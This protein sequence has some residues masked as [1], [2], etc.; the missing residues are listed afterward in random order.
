[1]LDPLCREA[2]TV[3]APGG[4]LLIVHSEVC[5]PDA[6]L[7]A[8]A[9]A[10]LAADV[11][12]RHRGPLGPRMR[13]RRRALEARGRLA[14]G[15]TSEEVLVLRGRLPSRGRAAAAGPLS[16][17]SSSPP[18]LRRPPPTP[19]SARARRAARFTRRP[20]TFPVTGR[21]G[22]VRAGAA[23]ATKWIA[24]RLG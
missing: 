1:V 18:S 24:S 20:S 21:A 9:A 13:S 15:R 10:G 12:A 14:P 11:A 3:L 19:A 6:T 16:P 8:L 22:L 7:R 2:P 23:Y 17:C 5:D 4:E